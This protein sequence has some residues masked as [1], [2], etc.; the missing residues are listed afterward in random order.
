MAGMRSEC[1]IP[2]N[3]GLADGPFVD[4]AATLSAKA[5]L[6]VPAELSVH[7]DLMVGVNLKEQGE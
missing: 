4:R 2:D 5:T 3:D 6:L 7:V 1:S